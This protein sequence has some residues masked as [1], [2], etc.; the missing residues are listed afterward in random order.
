ME[1]T[2]KRFT[3][4]ISTHQAVAQRLTLCKKPFE[5]LELGPF[6]LQA[7]SLMISP[8]WKGSLIKQFKTIARDELIK[9]GLVSESM[10]NTIMSDS[11]E[12]F[13]NEL[14]DLENARGPG[15]E[16]NYKDVD[17]DAFELSGSGEI[18]ISE[19]WSNELFE[20]FTTRPDT[21]NQKKFAKLVDEFKQVF[22][23]LNKLLPAG[24][25]V[26][27]EMGPNN[28]GLFTLVGG[29]EI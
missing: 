7:I 14:S 29:R 1:F 18:L 9:A 3:S 28:K 8:G 10:Q 23:E 19:T 22:E 24:V 27:E 26:I 4:T 11:V 16:R 15:M 17:I 20:Q 21:P 13:T 2:E 12:T 5:N 6:D 25:P